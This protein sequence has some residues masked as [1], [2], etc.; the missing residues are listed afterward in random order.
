MLLLQAKIWESS[1]SLFTLELSRSAIIIG[2]PFFFL[3]FFVLTWWFRYL[4]NKLYNPMRSWKKILIQLACN[5]Q[6]RAIFAALLRLTRPA[7]LWDLYAF[8]SSPSRFNN[9]NPKVRLVNEYYRLLGKGSL[10]SSIGTIEDGLFKLSNDWWRI[11]DVNASY[12]M[13]STYPFAL[14]VPK[15]IKWDILLFNYLSLI[16]NSLLILCYLITCDDDYRDTDLLKACTFRARCRLPV[17]SWCD[18]RK[19]W[20]QVLHNFLTK[21]FSWRIEFMFFSV[22]LCSLC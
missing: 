19:H 5:I 20:I 14:L 11:S 4:N 7:R 15:S 9:S 10:Q 21:S 22:I 12:N 3:H 16:G 17:I 18:N 6:R 13:C 1:Y 8:T 2:F